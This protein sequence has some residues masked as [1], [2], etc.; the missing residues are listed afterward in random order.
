MI[1]GA[2]KIPSTTI[3]KTVTE[4]APLTAL[5]KSAVDFSSFLLDSANTGMKAWDKAPS[6]NIRRKKFGILNAMKNAS[7]VIPAP[8]MVAINTSR[9]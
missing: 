6:A 9:I 4:R 1:N 2:D 5:I 7:V 3:P 8:N